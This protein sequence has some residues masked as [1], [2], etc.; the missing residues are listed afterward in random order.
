MRFRNRLLILVVAILV[1]AFIG[2]AI[3]VAYVY[4]EQQKDQERGVAETG[5]AFALLIDNEMRHQEGILRTLAASPALHEGDMAEFYAHAQRAAESVGAV[6]ILYDLAGKTVL[7]TR[8]PLGSG[9]A[10]TR[11]VEPAGAGAALRHGPH[12]GVG[13]LLCAAGGALR[14]HDAGAGP[15][16]GQ[17]RYHLLLGLHVGIVQ[18][19]LER[20]HFPDTWIATVVDRNGRIVARS[21]EPAGLS[22]RRCAPRP[23]AHQPPATRRWCSTARRA[24]ASRCGR[25]P[26]RCRTRAGRS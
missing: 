1:P 6:A 3:A 2:A 20:Q 17:V 22:A 5:H 11:P 13:Y 21:R 15:V 18:Q 7:N 10:G 12:P 19:L 24:T 4:L 25:S 26:A 9:G 16:E 14:L 8:R 23:Q